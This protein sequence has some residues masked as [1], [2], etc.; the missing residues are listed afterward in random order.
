MKKGFSFVVLIITLSGMITAFVTVHGY[1]NFKGTVEDCSGNPLSGATVILADCYSYI[2]AWDTTDSEGDYNF[3]VT[4]NGNSPYKLSASKTRFNTGVEDEIYSGGTYDFDLVGI[5]EKIAV[6]FWARDAT[7]ATHINRY[8]GYLGEGGEG[9][10]IYEYMDCEDVETVEEVCQDIDDYEIDADTI[11]VYIIGHGNTTGSHSYTYFKEGG[12]TQVYSNTFR[13]YMDA[14]EA[15]RKCILVD[16]CYAGYWVDDFDSEPYLA[17]SS[18][19]EETASYT[20][21][22]S[23]EG[24]FSHYFFYFVWT[25]D[26][27]EDAFDD[28]CD[29]IGD[30]DQNPQISDNSDY[31]WFGD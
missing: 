17:M 8:K 9:Y 25:G 15:N 6:F 20:Y 22:G 10:E 31:E 4:L 12:E 28:A 26:N 19:D 27:A 14:W 18:S 16:S 11:F 23:M 1:S 24:L 3:Y 29:F 13:N 5:G 30:E 21:Q 2:L 7:I